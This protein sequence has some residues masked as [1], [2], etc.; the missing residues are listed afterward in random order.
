MIKDISEIDHT[1]G[2]RDLYQ[3]RTERTND[4]YNVV[5]RVQYYVL[6]CCRP[7]GIGTGLRSP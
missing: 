4:Q 3:S 2:I 6:N 7:L 5:F 1:K